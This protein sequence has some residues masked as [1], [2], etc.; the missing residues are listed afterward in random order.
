VVVTGPP[1]GHHYRVVGVD[2]HPQAMQTPWS[3][4][5]V[6]QAFAAATATDSD[7]LR[8][9]WASQPGWQRQMEVRLRELGWAP[10][11]AS[12]PWVP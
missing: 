6:A 12:P 1:P 5:L 2:D 9:T 8:R 7:Y 10:N 4:N 11:A 3:F